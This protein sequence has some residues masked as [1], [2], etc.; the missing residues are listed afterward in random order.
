[1]ELTTED[2]QNLS[3]LLLSVDDDNTRI[4]FEI[5]NSQQAFP[6]ELFTETFVI[7]KLS[8]DNEIRN[9]AYHF[10][11]KQANADITAIFNTN[12]M[13]GQRGDVI[14][15]EQ[16]IRKNIN[17]YVAMSND[18][19]DGNKMALALYHKYGVGLN[20]LLKNLS[21]QLKINLLKSFIIGTTFKLNNCSLSKI[22]EEL[23]AFTN[24]TEIDLSHNKIKTISAKIKVFKKLESLIIS[25]NQINKL[26]KVL[27]TL[28]NLK[29]LDISSNKFKEFPPVL[30]KLERLEELNIYELH[31]TM[32]GEVYQVPDAFTQLKHLKKINSSGN[33]YSHMGNRI[34]ISLSDFPNFS[35]VTSTGDAPLDLRPMHLAKYAYETN[36]HSEGVFYLFKYCQDRN[37][38]TRIIEEQ[39]Y[40]SNKKLLDLKNTILDD[41]PLEIANYD[42][43][44]LDFKHSCLGTQYYPAGLYSRYSEVP[45]KTKEEI[46]KLFAVFE[47][48]QTIQSVDLSF[49]CLV[50]VPSIVFKW[51]TLARLDLRNN[52]LTEIPDEIGNLQQLEYL[53]LFKN[54][55]KELPSSFKSLQNLKVL[56]LGYNALDKVPEE[57][58]YLQNLEELHFYNPH[59]S[60]PSAEAAKNIPASFGLLKN[61]KKIRFYVNGMYYDKDNCK[62]AY[63]NRLQELLPD[64]CKIELD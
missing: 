21:D 18:Q 36:G 8:E 6:K 22:P 42:L 58:G 13:L 32:L 7:Y 62:A 10:L 46:D 29:K 51:D 4:A 15:T 57:I 12:I 38:I 27:A 49:N 17:S 1:M 45:F 25:K 35:T 19:L 54:N 48:F 61:L 3:E 31:Y 40:D 53:D 43:H 55:L 39:Y 60:L 5:M 47:N 16:T 63:L 20:F 44:H 9:S 14:P 34:K 59:M 41:L 28:P 50:E 23:Y 37:L 2:L 24:L 11:Q 26:N 56:I 64:D 30:A 52:R 33:S